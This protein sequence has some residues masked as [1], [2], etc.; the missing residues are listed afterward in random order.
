MQLPRKSVPQL[1]AVRVQQRQQRPGE[2]LATVCI[3]ALAVV[4]DALQQEPVQALQ[5]LVL[6]AALVVRHG[7][8]HAPQPGLL[9]LHTLRLGL[10]SPSQ[11]VI[12]V[13]AQVGAAMSPVLGRV[14]S[15]SNTMTNKS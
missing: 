6:H 1:P 13:R 14:I 9:Y 8:D 4:L 5:G 11:Q 2:R 3:T 10:R 7:W 15:S 12:R